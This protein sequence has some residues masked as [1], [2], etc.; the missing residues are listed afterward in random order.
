[1]KIDLFCTGAYTEIGGL[2]SFLERTLAGDG[3]AVEVSRRFPA[4]TKPGPRI[5]AA[6]P[7]A[8]HSGVTGPALVQWMTEILGAYGTEADLIVLADDADCRWCPDHAAWVRWQAE[9]QHAVEAA[10]GR[11]IQVVTLLA[12]PEVEAW[13][14]ADWTRGFQSLMRD[15]V[16]DIHAATKNVIG[17]APPAGVEEFG[18]PQVNGACS[19]KLSDALTAALA[20]REIRYSKRVDGPVMLRSL[21]ADRVAEHCP[22][23]FRRALADLRDCVRGRAPQSG[24]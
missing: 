21:A 15:R 7:A 17:V 20:A 14:V 11:R 23:Y 1:M 22:I 12:S 13:F 24:G 6:A 16:G 4:V 10:V 5:D 2:S 18:C 3:A 19:T 8:R 9:V